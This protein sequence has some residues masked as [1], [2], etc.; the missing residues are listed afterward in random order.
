[1]IEIPLSNIQCNLELSSEIQ[2]KIDE[3]AAS[4]LEQGLLHPITVHELNTSP[5]TYQVLAGKKRFY[6]CKSLDMESISCEVRRELTPDQQEEISLHENLKRGHLPWYDEVILVAKLHEL[7]QRQHGASEAKR[8]IGGKKGWGMRDTAAELGKALGAVSM[9][10]SLAKM[11]MMNPAM[12]KIRDKSTATKLI[13]QTTKRLS[14]EEEQYM[15]SSSVSCADEIYCGDSA[16]IL[17]QLPEMVFDFCITDPPWVKFEKSDDKSLKRDIDT[18]KVFKSLFRCMK[19]NSFVYIIVS[20]E[21]FYFYQRELPKIGYKVQ[22]H[23]CAWHKESFLS[24]TGVKGWEHGRDMELILLAVKGSPVL[25]L[26][27]QASSI[28][29]HA[30]VPSKLLIHPNEKPMALLSAIAEVCSFDGSLGI[31]PFG[32]SGSFAEMCLKNNRHYTVIEREPER[33]K[34]ILER[35]EKMK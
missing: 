12:K 33:Y 4:I 11:V 16:T 14:A 2:S 21:D 31:D 25:A 23:P 32:G 6:A 20:T 15:T 5:A 34:K 8:P 29:R 26:S 17:D 9:D 27:T 10:I 28:F 18:L 7:R 22:G 35:L 1:M 19:W 30:V 24:R 13:N 3:I